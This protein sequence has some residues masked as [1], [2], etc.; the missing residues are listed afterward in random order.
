MAEYMGKN[1]NNHLGE[2][3]FIMRT[4]L[5][6]Y[7]KSSIKWELISCNKD[8]IVNQWKR[9]KSLVADTFIYGK[10]VN[11]NYVSNQGQNDNLFKVLGENISYLVFYLMLSVKYLPD[12]AKACTF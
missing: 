3:R 4:F 6:R 1:S 12:G 2:K 11:K 8:D 10:A 5:I 7:L 9:R